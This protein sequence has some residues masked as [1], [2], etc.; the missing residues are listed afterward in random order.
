MVASEILSKKTKNNSCVKN[1][2][3]RKVDEYEDPKQCYND[4]EFK[5][6]S[7]MMI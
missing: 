5:G 2:Y 3:R 1:I 6:E 4:N 7:M